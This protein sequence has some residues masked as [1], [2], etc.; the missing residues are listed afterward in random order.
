LSEG[1]RFWSE[2]TDINSLFKKATL[3]LILS[4]ADS[5][6]SKNIDWPE[7]NDLNKNERPLILQ[8]IVQA[9]PPVTSPKTGKEQG[10][11]NKQGWVCRDG[12]AADWPAAVTLV[13]RLR[14]IGL[15][16]FSRAKEAIAE[17]RLCVEQ[18]LP[19]LKRFI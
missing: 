3:F 18:A 13:P 7:I 12:F 11:G 17:G 14:H 15:M 10:W 4:Y 2:D 19:M 5:I 16:E 6:T 1:L 8:A 9:P